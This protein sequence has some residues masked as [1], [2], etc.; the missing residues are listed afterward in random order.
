MHR[1]PVLSGAFIPPPGKKLRM[2]LPCTGGI[3]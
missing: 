2:L 1:N 3:I